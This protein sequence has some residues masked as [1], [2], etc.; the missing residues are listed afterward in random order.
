MKI[1]LKWQSTHTNCAFMQPT[2]SGCGA[3]NYHITPTYLMYTPRL[4]F[5]KVS[6]PRACYKVGSI[7]TNE[8]NCTTETNLGS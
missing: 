3:L 4:S 8:G 5:R 1:I 7:Y 6:R 2:R